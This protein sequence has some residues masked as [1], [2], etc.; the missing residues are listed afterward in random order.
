M[1]RRGSAAVELVAAAPLFAA[2][3]VVTLQFSTLFT[4]EVA[5][6]AAAEAEASRMVHEWEIA[7]EGK[8]RSLP[9][10]ERM[11]VHS[12]RSEVL[13]TPI[14]MGSWRRDVAVPEEVWIVD[15][16]VCGD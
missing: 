6:V 11:E 12:A 16:P 15:E 4:R 13:A 1:T 14:G 2:M 8:G 9:C 5:A 7:K 10:L 3:I